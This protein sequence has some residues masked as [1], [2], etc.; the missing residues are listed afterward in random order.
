[1]E[2]C[3]CTIPKLKSLV[4][5]DG[6]TCSICNRWYLPE[7]GSN[8]VPEPPNTELGT[9]GS[10]ATTLD[11][12]PLPVT[13]LPDIGRNDPC[14][15]GSKK[16]YKK[17]CIKFLTATVYS[18]HRKSTASSAALHRIDPLAIGAP[19]EAG[20]RSKRRLHL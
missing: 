18:A 13:D 14:P 7:H 5:S 2:V 17:C 19:D 9:I 16:K 12:A 8:P 20:M 11:F 1:M 4:G 15:C 10:A 6:L 3:N